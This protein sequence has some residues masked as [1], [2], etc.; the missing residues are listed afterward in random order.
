MCTHVH[1]CKNT[2]AVTHTLHSPGWNQCDTYKW[3]SEIR[4]QTESPVRSLLDPKPWRSEQGLQGQPLSH[5][6]ESLLVPLV[7]VPALAFAPSCIMHRVMYAPPQAVSAPELAPS[8]SC[9]CGGLGWLQRWARPCSL[10]FWMDRTLK[11]EGRR[12][13]S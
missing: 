12:W 8:L 7:S 9:I 5:G 10:S 11:N 13:Y 6:K 3:K 4:P 1:T 2:H